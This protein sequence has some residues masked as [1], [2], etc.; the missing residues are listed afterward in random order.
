MM[1]PLDTAG[2]VQCTIT[3]YGLLLSKVILVG[4]LSGAEID[5]HKVQL[6][7]THSHL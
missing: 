6:Y 4:G 1:I 7:I 2:G 5:P 3:L